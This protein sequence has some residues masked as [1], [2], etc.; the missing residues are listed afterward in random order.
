MK[1]TN[2]MMTQFELSKWS[3]SD[4]EHSWECEDCGVFY[5]CDILYC[6]QC[7]EKSTLEYENCPG[8]YDDSKYREFQVR[9]YR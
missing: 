2:N 6:E 7:G 4:Q 5:F 9:T 8:C 3:K 1:T